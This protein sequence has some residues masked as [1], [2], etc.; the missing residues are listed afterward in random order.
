MP[1]NLTPSSSV[2]A[3]EMVDKITVALRDNPIGVVTVSVD[4]QTV[5]YSRAQALDELRFWQQQAA[6]AAGTRPR[7]ARINLSGC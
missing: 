2:T 3:A 4:G 7:V 1:I 5:T 6:R